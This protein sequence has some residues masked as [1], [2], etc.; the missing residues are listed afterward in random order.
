[1][2]S[3][4]A[5]PRVPYALMRTL[6]ALER[7]TLAWI[8]TALTFAT[9]GLGMIGY[10]RSLEQSQHD[11]HAAH[12]HTVAIRMGVALV[13]LGLVSLLLTA[14]G[15]QRAVAR[16]RRG[17]LPRVDGLPLSVANAVLCALICLYGLWVFTR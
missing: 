17:E 13:L 3:G 8:R 11:A 15:H 6:L 1:M 9:F 10:F 5:D 12:L 14:V 16:L 4:Q 7:T 2:T